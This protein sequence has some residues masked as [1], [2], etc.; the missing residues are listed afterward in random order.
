MQ[1]GGNTDASADYVLA[2]GSGS[3]YK[4]IK[5]SDQEPRTDQFILDEYN[6]F[7]SQGHLLRTWVS[8]N[9]GQGSTIDT[10]KGIF[11]ISPAL[12]WDA[13]GDQKQV[14]NV[15]QSICRNYENLI[16]TTPDYTI[17]TTVAAY[18]NVSGNSGQID[19][20]AVN[21]LDYEDR[22]GNDR[23][24]YEYLLLIGDKKH[25]K[26]YIQASP[27]AKDLMSNASGGTNQTEIAGL[28]YLHAEDN[29]TSLANI[30]WKPL[31][32]EDNTKSTVE[33]R[34]TTDDTY[35]TTGASFSKS[36]FIEFDEPLD[37]SA[38]SMYDLMGKNSDYSGWGNAEG[39]AVSATPT[40]NNFEFK[41]TATCSAT[42]TT[43]QGKTATFV[44]TGD[45]WPTALSGNTDGIGAYKYLAVLHSGNMVG[46]TANAGAAYWVADGFDD[47][48]DGT[49]T[50][51]LQIGD[52]L[53]WGGGA[54]SVYGKFIVTS[55]TYVFTFRRINWYDVIDGAS[56]VWSSNPTGAAA[57]A[58]KVNPVDSKDGGTWLNYFSFMSGSAAGA[59]MD[60]KWGNN[61]YYVLKMVLKGNK[62]Q[63]GSTSSSPATGSGAGVVGTE[64]WNIL[65]YDNSFSQ[66][67]EEIDD[68]AY[69]LN[70]IPL[71]SDVSVGRKGNFY[72]AITRKG[73]VYIAKTGI[74]IE[75]I[76]FSSVALGDEGDSK[77]D[78]FDDHGPGT[79]YGY[80]RK[81]R[82]LQA[83]SVRVYWDEQQKDGTY[84]RFWGI[85]T[86]VTDTRGASGPRSVVNYSF[87]MTVEEIAI[88]DGNKDLITDIYPLGGIE[89]VR[90]Y[91]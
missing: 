71:T 12:N 1:K 43:T 51:K 30:Y 2:L 40:A 87:N 56:K 15:T 36:G 13:T 35:S 68:H 73:K 3:N 53:F 57:N 58:F 24:A 44:R 47:G 54:P 78:K 85:I 80:L 38:V 32:F 46:P 61:D 17:D 79:L 69:S 64:V 67:V 50:F 39:S 62:Y 8:G 31:K 49:N 86:D 7:V 63:S 91:S 66:F 81:V 11:R 83:D 33:Y 9:G 14:G 23:T 10:Y 26:I 55:Q 20:D 60:S 21:T 6:R 89:D 76:S 75:K 4:W 48:Y 37:W 19:L 5:G 59:A 65:P 84:I 22:E 45:T 25:N 72:Q 18:N 41:I 77:S 88:Y 42:G 16:A 27:Y 70:S 90:T 34:N 52:E 82:N 29:K 28:Y 74:G